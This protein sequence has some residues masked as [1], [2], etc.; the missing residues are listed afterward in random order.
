MRLF[1]RFSNTFYP[2]GLKVSVS[3]DNDATSM[4]LKTI[5]DTSSPT[6]STEIISWS[7]RNS[8][9]M[10]DFHAEITW[11]SGDTNTL[12]G[13]VQKEPGKYQYSFSILHNEQ[14]QLGF[15]LDLLCQYHQDLELDVKGLTQLEFPSHLIKHEVEIIQRRQLVSRTESIMWSTSESSEPKGLK[16]QYRADKNQG[17]SVDYTFWIQRISSQV[18]ETFSSHY[19]KTQDKTQLS[20]SNQHPSDESRCLDWKVNTLKTINLIFF[21]IINCCEIFADGN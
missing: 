9:S 19:L 11:V 5:G 6:T 4:T 21:F 12:K 1:L 14:R 10:T 3:Y 8:E 18:T 20:I 15:D 13:L 7:L 2:S 17:Q 16:Y